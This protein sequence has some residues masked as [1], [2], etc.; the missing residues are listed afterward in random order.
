MRFVWLKGH[1]DNPYNNRCDQLATEAADSGILLED[2][3][4]NNKDG[5]LF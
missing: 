1:A 2:E 4:F 3:G 5:N